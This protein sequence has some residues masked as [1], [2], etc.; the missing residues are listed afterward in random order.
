M[1]AASELTYTSLTGHLGRSGIRVYPALLQK[2]RM[3]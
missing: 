2:H 3:P 1:F